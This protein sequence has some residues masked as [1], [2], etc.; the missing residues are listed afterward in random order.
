MPPAEKVAWGQSPH[1]GPPKPACRRLERGIVRRPQRGRHVCGQGKVRCAPLIAACEKLRCGAGSFTGK[2]AR[3]T[4]RPSGQPKACSPHEALA[5]ARLVVPVA[6]TSHRGLGV[7]ELAP[8][9]ARPTGHATQ[10]VPFH[11]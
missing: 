11:P 9:E 6:H 4:A 5:G 8:G 3:H 2:L 10:L 7:V 1:E